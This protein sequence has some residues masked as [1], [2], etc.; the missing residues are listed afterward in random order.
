VDVEVEGRLHVI[1]GSPPTG[2]GTATGCPFAPRC[3]RVMQRCHDEDPPLERVPDGVASHE[4]AC[5]A[6]V[7]TGSAP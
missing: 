2:Y 5:F 4:A 7:R 1:P 3:S 6:D